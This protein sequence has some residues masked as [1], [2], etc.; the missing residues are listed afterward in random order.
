MNDIIFGNVITVIDKNTLQI[1]LTFEMG[2]NDFDYNDLENVKYISLTKQSN[3]INDEQIGKE[4]LEKYL[5][6][7][8]VEC[9]IFGMDNFS[10]LIGKVILLEDVR[11]EKKQKYFLGRQN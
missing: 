3:K 7:H 11:E 2:N 8:E 9:H 4:Q 1:D 6:G 10:R 5:L